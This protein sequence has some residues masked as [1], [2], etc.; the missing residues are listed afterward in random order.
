MASQYFNQNFIFWNRT[1]RKS[2]QER[3][4]QVPGHRVELV[5]ELLLA[6]ALLLPGELH[7]GARSGDP[8]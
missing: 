4:L 8:D 5:D 6:V 1:M 7:L 2:H 3:R